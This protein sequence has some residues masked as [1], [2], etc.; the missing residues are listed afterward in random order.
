MDTPTDPPSV[1]TSSEIEDALRQAIERLLKES[2]IVLPALSDLPHKA[3][4]YKED[5]D[6]ARHHRFVDKLVDTAMSGAYMA[7]RSPPTVDLSRL[8]GAIISVLSVGAAASCARAPDH[9]GT[10]LLNTVIDAHERYCHQRARQIQTALEAR[11]VWETT[12]IYR[13]ISKGKIDVD[14]DAEPR[15]KALLEREDLLPTDKDEY[16]AVMDAL[17]VSKEFIDGEQDIEKKS[18]AFEGD[19]GTKQRGAPETAAYTVS[20]AWPHLTGATRSRET[21]GKARDLSDRQQAVLSAE[22]AFGTNCGR[23]EALAYAE[24]VFRTDAGYEFQPPRDRVEPAATGDVLVQRLNGVVSEYAHALHA[25]AKAGLIHV[26]SREE[27]LRPE[28]HL[29]AS[30]DAVR[31]E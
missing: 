8:P 11:L 12:E 3:K 15:F 7:P 20:R 13:A 21:L 25:R 30:G 27:E 4:A 23:Q 28:E 14:K 6:E 10:A 29:P 2:G 24:H 22:G 18:P 9:A 17:L 16:A 1:P 19:T 5:S 31:R 26:K